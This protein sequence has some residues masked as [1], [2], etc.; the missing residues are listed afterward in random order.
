MSEE[1][2]S[3]VQLMLAASLV[4]AAFLVIL[5]CTWKLVRLLAMYKMESQIE[6]LEALSAAQNNGSAS[7]ADISGLMS[8][9]DARNLR[10][11]SIL[12]GFDRKRPSRSQRSSVCSANTTTPALARRGFRITASP[13]RRMTEMLTKHTSNRPRRDHANSNGRLASGTGNYL[14][15]RCATEAVGSRGAEAVEAPGHIH[16]RRCSSSG[17]FI[18]DCLTSPQ[19]IDS[20]TC[21]PVLGHKNH[22]SCAIH[23]GYSHQ[24]RISLPPNK[25]STAVQTVPAAQLPGS[26]TSQLPKTPPPPRPPSGFDVIDE[27]C[28]SPSS[29]CEGEAAD[30]PQST[31]WRASDLHHHLHHHQADSSESD[32]KKPWMRCINPNHFHHHHHHHDPATTLP[33]TLTHNPVEDTTMAAL[34]FHPPEYQC[35]ICQHNASLYRA[36]SNPNIFTRPHNPGGGPN[37]GGLQNTASASMGKKRTSANGLAGDLSHV[38]EHHDKICE[39]LYPRSNNKQTIC[40][41]SHP[42]LGGLDDDESESEDTDEAEVRDFQ[43]TYPMQ[44]IKS[45]IKKLWLTDSNFNTF[46]VCLS[47]FFSL[48]FL[49]PSF[50]LPLLNSYFAFSSFLT[51]N[52][53]SVSLVVLE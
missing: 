20:N 28:M 9:K 41:D 36:L 33:I 13:I 18:K 48:R 30:S 15:Q 39:D 16:H 24:H 6:D 3:Y 34:L 10:K 42:G 2:G 32:S 26:T 19:Q 52:Y 27:E 8:P 21:S 37:G 49:F 11:L 29:A 1:G 17:G 38:S 5:T 7:F 40:E 43:S 14:L 44:I 50:F 35:V 51:E 31:S 12:A 25:V 45:L 46:K 4:I 22:S 47:L 23:G 53:L